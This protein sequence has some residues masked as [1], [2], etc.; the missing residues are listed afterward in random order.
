MTTK[1]TKKSLIKDI[2]ELTGGEFKE[3]FFSDNGSTINKSALL[4]VK[5]ALMSHGALEKPAAPA[6]PQ[7]PEEIIRLIDGLIGSE[8][9][10]YEITPESVIKIIKK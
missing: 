1:N 5:E 6:P 10:S 9:A 4:A 2:L 3:D 7:D 8:V